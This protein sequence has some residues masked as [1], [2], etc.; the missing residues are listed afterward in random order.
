[1][2]LQKLIEAIGENENPLTPHQN[3]IKN[4]VLDA[5][6]SGVNKI[7]VK[8][9]AGVGKTFMV[10]YLIQEFRKSNNYGLISITA[11]TNRAVT[12]LMSKEPNAPYWMTFSTIHKALFLKRKIDE[13]SGKVSFSPDYNPSKE[14][15]FRNCRLIMID[16]AS[17]LNSEL[18]YYLEDKAY[19]H[20]PMIFL[21]DSKQLPPVGEDVSPIF[22][23]K[24]NSGKSIELLIGGDKVVHEV[25]HYEE[26]ELTE[27]IR[28]SDGNPIIDLSYNLPKVGLL[29][30]NLN[31]KGE[32]Y[33]YTADLQFCIDLVKGNDDKVRYLSWTNSDVDKVNKIIRTQIYSTPQKVEEGETIVFAEPYQGLKDNYFNSYE[34][35]IKELSVKS[36]LFRPIFK[37]S[38]QDDGQ[39]QEITIEEELTYYLINN[40]VRIIHE[41]SYFKFLEITKHLKFLT[42]KGLT[43]KAYYGFVESFARFGYRYA[44]TVHKAQGGTFDTVVINM[45]TLNLNRKIS[46]RNSLWYTALTR[47][48]KKVVIYNAPFN[49]LEI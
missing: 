48:A 49:N 25:P 1:M 24:E 39:P 8:G 43:W 27:I 40:D 18:L 9:S 31:Q 44:M 7:I 4:K 32:G 46:E 11:P 13:K 26:F 2:D 29:E 33:I 45:K 10:K 28:Q 5:I 42:K 21:G 38:Y 3:S 17:M 23:R 36:S 30:D 22:L 16:E 35:K 12:V 41:D 37:F 14:A 20:I 47:A 6:S 15:P 34:L 19:A